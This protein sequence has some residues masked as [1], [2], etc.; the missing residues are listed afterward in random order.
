MRPNALVVCCHPNPKSYTH[1]VFEAVRAG[2]AEGGADVEALDLYAEG[3]DPVLVVDEERR[4]RDL[5]KVAYTRRHREQLARCDA[6]VF[7]YP[8]WWGGFPA[9]LKGYVDR[10]FVSGLAYSFAG[11]PKDA[12]L[13]DGLMRG[14]EA[15][16]FYTLD[17]PWW[18]ALADPG[19]FS[20][21][22]TLFRYCGFGVVRRHYLARLKLTTHDERARWLAEVRSRAARIAAGLRRAP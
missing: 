15:H 8:V 22:F 4:R 5:D 9:V 20:N 6:V 7:V 21:E 17:S 12:V 1:A 18:V 2:L 14:K 16:C 19:W 3:F 11:R 13:P 10:T